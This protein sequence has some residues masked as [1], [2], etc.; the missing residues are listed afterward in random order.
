MTGLFGEWPLTNDTYSSIFRRTQRQFYIIFQASHIASSSHFLSG[1]KY[2]RNCSRIVFR[3]AISGL[4]YADEPY[5]PTPKSSS[6][7]REGRCIHRYRSVADTA[8][9][10]R[11]RP[12]RFS[13]ELKFRRTFVLCPKKRRDMLVFNLV[14]SNDR[15][16]LQSR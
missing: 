3:E 13:A 1:Q 12:H 14:R 11:L 5:P 8:A 9:K 6:Q 16:N 15:D 10:N 7:V 2:T 4:F